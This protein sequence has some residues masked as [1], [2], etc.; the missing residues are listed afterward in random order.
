M[1][2]F[3]TAGHLLAWA[4]C[5]GQNESAGKRKSSRLRKGAPWL[6]TMLVQCA[7]GRKKKDSYYKAQ[8]QR[9][10]SRVARRKRSAPWPP[11]CSPRST[12]CS[13]T[14]PSIRT[15]RRSFRP[16][17]PRSRPGTRSLN[18]P[19]S[20]TRRASAPG[21]GRL[22]SAAR[23]TRLLRWPSGA[24]TPQVGS[25]SLGA[26]RRGN[27]HRSAQRDGDCFAT[28]AM[29]GKS[30]AREFLFAFTRLP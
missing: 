22:M 30:D 11:R 18:S 13:R 15:W 6:K 9:L 1:S 23:S 20:D 12:T 19:G 21:P 24:D 25:F 27:L 7:A 8:F 26:K 10:K 28:L 29:T 2:R 4:G 14:V 5:A 3:A 16:P 17:L